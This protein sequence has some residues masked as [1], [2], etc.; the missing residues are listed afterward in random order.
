[1]ASQLNKYNWKSSRVNDPN[2]KVIQPSKQ[3]NLISSINDNDSPRATE[4]SYIVKEKEDLRRSRSVFGRKK[5][6]LGTDSKSFQTFSNCIT[7]SN[8]DY[9]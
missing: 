9:N 4:I 5:I 2:V 8:M 7:L 3:K 1:M 6:Q